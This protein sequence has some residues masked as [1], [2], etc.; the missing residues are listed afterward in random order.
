MIVILDNI[1]VGPTF[2]S[3]ILE[4][5]PED[6]LGDELKDRWF[7]LNQEHQFDNFC[8]ELIKLAS[9]FYDLSS[10]IGYEFW[11]QN[12]TRPFDW[13]QDRD[14]ELGTQGI[15]SFPLCSMVYYLVVENLQGGKLHLEDD[16]ITPKTDRLV[17]F[18]PGKY[19]MV[20]PFEGKRVSLLINPWNRS[21]NKNTYYYK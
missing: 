12:N 19:H 11:T 10:C 20:D 2:R 13:H 7:S 4:I 14:E 1:S 21:L 8:T 18:P 6:N 17:I 9:D 3:D 5:L 15:E 16:I